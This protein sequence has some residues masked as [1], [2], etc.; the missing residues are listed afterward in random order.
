MKGKLGNLAIL[1][2]VIAICVTVIDNN[3]CATEFEELYV[4]KKP[5]KLSR[6]HRGT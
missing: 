6:L 5:G 3:V 1:Y 4:A 2:H